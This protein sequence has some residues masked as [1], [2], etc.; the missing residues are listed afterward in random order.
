VTDMNVKV[1]RIVGVIKFRNNKKTKFTI[2]V[3]AVRPEHAIETIYSNLSGLHRVK[4][5]NINI[6]SIH[7]IDP[8]ESK[9]ILVKSIREMA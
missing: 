1:Y 5:Y 6:D 2:D 7:V 3:P 4:R 8:Q 9:N